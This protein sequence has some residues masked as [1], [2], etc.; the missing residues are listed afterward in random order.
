MTAERSATILMPFNAKIFSTIKMAKI[1]SGITVAVW[2][3]YSSQW[4]FIVKTVKQTNQNPGGCI[5]VLSSNYYY[6][7]EIFGNVFYSLLPCILIFIF[8]ITIIVKLALAKMKSKESNQTSAVSKGA[9]N[10]TLMLLS[11]SVT[12]SIL[13]CPIAV[14]YF[15]FLDYYAIQEMRF[16]TIFLYYTNHSC[17]AVM[18][19]MIS[20][21]FRREIKKSLCNY[22]IVDQSSASDNSFV[23]KVGPS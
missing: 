6:Y 3:V 15:I 16:L 5:Y 2:G 8:N 19:T 7:Y 12:F 22:N 13:T 9:Q 17:N 20:P 18:Y 14:Y 10:T 1:I 11:A 4:F 21:K 23:N